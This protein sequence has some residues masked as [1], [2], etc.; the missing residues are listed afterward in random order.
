MALFLNHTPKKKKLAFTFGKCFS[1]LILK[2]TKV[3]VIF[4]KAQ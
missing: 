3:D 4:F 1:H 2:E